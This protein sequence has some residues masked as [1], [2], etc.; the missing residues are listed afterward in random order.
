MA[1]WS[2]QHR[3]FAVEAFF[4]NND[5]F[6]ATRRAFRTHF[7]LAP[8]ATLPNNRSIS[9]WVEHFRLHGNVLPK[10]ISTRVPTV[11][12]PE[13]VDR[14]RV[15]VEE[16]PRRSTRKRA[17]ALG[18]SRR[19]L[20]T[21]LAKHL[22]FHPYKIVVVQRLLPTDNVQRVTFS[23]RM[24][25]I[26]RDEL[27]IVITSDEA[28]FHLDGNV[29]KQNCRYW[30]SDNPRELHQQPL[31]SEK[32]T[33]WCALSKV[34]IIGPYFFENQRGQALVINSERYVAMLR[35]FFI[36]YLEEN[37]W[38][39]NNIWFQQDGATAHT[40]R[41]SVD[42][43]HETFPGRLISRNGDVPWPPRSPD[44]APCDFFLWGY[45]KSKVY[46]D[47]PRTI[48]QLKEAIRREIGA[49]PVE[50]LGDVMRNFKDRLQECVT[51]DGQHLSE[52][53]FHN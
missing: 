21:I 44:L 35:E 4:R 15:S 20:Q 18:I 11:V 7:N 31:H 23:E 51:V 13:N 46:V 30:A 24:L 10:N 50:M 27:S 14:V 41:V 6:A 34:G 36:P 45:L 53:I 37:E 16:S 5:S 17:Q 26:L 52:I 43:L 38:D 22:K 28:H 12:T 8:R 19:S 47:K 1:R 2:V 33:V 3:S 25:D 48:P 49:I 9:K 42:V 29:N 32:V 39:I 40:A